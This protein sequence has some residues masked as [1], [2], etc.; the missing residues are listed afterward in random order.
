MSAPE[1][2]TLNTL[3]GF[4][5]QGTTLAASSLLFHKPVFQAAS[6]CLRVHHDSFLLLNPSF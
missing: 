2:N 3:Y 1:A 6:R 5:P 4:Q